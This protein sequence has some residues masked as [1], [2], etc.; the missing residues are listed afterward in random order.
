MPN[1]KVLLIRRELTFMVNALITNLELAQYDV[2]EV[3]LSPKTISYYKDDADIMILYADDELYHAHST[4]ELL[5]E[6]CLRENKL[7]ILIGSKREAEDISSILPPHL[8]TDIMERP[9]DISLLIEKISALLDKEMIEQK[10]KSILL[11]DD[12]VSYLLLLKE[13]L[14]SRFRIGLAR[15]GMQAITWIARNNVDLILLD[16]NMPVTD[17][18]QVFE[19]LKSE[20]FSKDI[21]VMFLTGKSDKESI[22]KV[23]ELKPAGYMLKTINQETLLETLDN[24]FSDK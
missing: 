9:L 6:L 21:P 11:V 12:D 14:S 23:M 18:K 5:K 1:Y 2:Q 7:L 22:M 17:G 16:Y 15:S 19:M 24:F 8:L 3:G 13:W 10:K 20:E 4:L